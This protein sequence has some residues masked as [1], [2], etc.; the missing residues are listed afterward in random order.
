MTKTQQSKN[1]NED[2]ETMTTKNWGTTNDAQPIENLIN[3]WGGSGGAATMQP[4]Y[5]IIMWSC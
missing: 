2:E 5:S 1:E 3:N 4:S